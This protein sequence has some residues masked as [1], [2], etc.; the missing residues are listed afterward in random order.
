MMPDTLYNIG[1]K[2]G[3]D[4][5]TH[6]YCPYYEMHLPNR[7]EK[8]NLLEIGIFD[9]GSLRMWQEYFYNATIYGVD[10]DPDTIF[11]DERI[12]T[13][14]GDASSDSFWNSIDLPEFTVIIDDGSHQAGDIV[15]THSILWPRLLKGGF[16]V[17]EDLL[18]QWYPWYG[19]NENGSVAIR[20][21][22]S[23][24]H[25]TLRTNDSS[26]LHCYLELAILKK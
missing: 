17:I 3:T 21:L 25:H 8:F 18:V 26:E 5:T 12:S 16:Y 22:E 15:K 6:G 4:K 13:F 23:R 19:G 7:D 10:I 24:M 20:E 1:C 14:C 9:G 11:Q 2:Y